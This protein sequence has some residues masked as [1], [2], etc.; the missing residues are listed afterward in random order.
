MSGTALLFRVNPSGK[1]Q[2]DEMREF[3]AGLQDDL[4][5]MFGRDVVA[6]LDE[7]ERMHEALKR[8]AS[9]KPD[10]FVNA[11]NV[12]RALDAVNVAREALS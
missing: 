4:G 10:I 3:A 6:A 8:I 7:A 5:P 11:D 1:R 2:I 9:I 12:R